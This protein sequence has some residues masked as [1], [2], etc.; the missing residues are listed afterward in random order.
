MN[1]QKYKKMDTLPTVNRV[2]FVSKPSLVQTLK[3]MEIGIALTFS[4]HDFKTQYARVAISDLR[5]KG[6]EFKITEEGL[7]DEYIITRLK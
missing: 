4:I 5:K 6:F 3:T 2:K 7:V 1:S